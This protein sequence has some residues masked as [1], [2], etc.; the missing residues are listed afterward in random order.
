MPVAEAAAYLMEALMRVV[1]G[2]LVSMGYI[3]LAVRE[4]KFGKNELD[5]V[6]LDKVELDKVELA[7]K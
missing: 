2:T 3:K 7:E 1:C 4:T 5:E 6:E